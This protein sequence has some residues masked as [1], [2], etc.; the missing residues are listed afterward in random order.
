MRRSNVETKRSNKSGRRIPDSGIFPRGKPIDSETGGLTSDWKP[1]VRIVQ[2]GPL[3][4]IFFHYEVQWSYDLNIEN[5][6]IVRTSFHLYSVVRNAT[7][8]GYAAHRSRIP[9]SSSEFC[10]TTHLQHCSSQTQSVDNLC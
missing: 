10:T 4:Q 8:R 7:D 5:T 3:N 1:Y 6:I 9:R 2:N